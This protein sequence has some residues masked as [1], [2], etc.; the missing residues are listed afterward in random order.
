MPAPVSPYRVFSEKIFITDF[1]SY[2]TKEGATAKISELKQKHGK[3]LARVVER[4]GY[5]TIYFEE[6]FYKVIFGKLPPK[7][8]VRVTTPRKKSTKKAEKP[9]LGTEKS[10]GK[11]TPIKLSGPFAPTKRGSISPKADNSG[12]TKIPQK[13][14]SPAGHKKRSLA[15]PPM[16]VY[17]PPPPYLLARMNKD[18]QKYYLA[19]EI[20][21]ERMPS[22]QVDKLLEIFNAE[23]L[24]FDVNFEKERPLIGRIKEIQN[25]LNVRKRKFDDEIIAR[26]LAEKVKVPLDNGKFAKVLQ[27]Y[28]G[29]NARTVADAIIKALGR[30]R[31]EC[32]L[33][34]YALGQ[35]IANLLKGKFPDKYRD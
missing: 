24:K 13:I 25:A 30:S 7:P 35:E 6:S 33:S 26:F 11:K 20:V 32:P 31:K 28:D 19:K 21:F 12:R 5:F 22:K 9:C 34:D 23:I 3:Y 27:K 4:K 29:F 18:A 15:T 16:E 8:E 17:G 10:G 14:S 1:S 2:A